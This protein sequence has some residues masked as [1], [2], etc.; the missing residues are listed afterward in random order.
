MLI[1]SG[2]L[3][4]VLSCRSTLD[5]GFS[6]VMSSSKMWLW[7]TYVGFNLCLI[8]FGDSDLQDCG[9]LFKCVCTS[10]LEPHVVHWAENVSVPPEGKQVPGHLCVGNSVSFGVPAE[11]HLFMGFQP[12][13]VSFTG[14]WSRCWALVTSRLFLQCAPLLKGT[15]CVCGFISLWKQ[16]MTIIILVGQWAKARPK[17]SLRELFCQAK[18]PFDEM[19]ELI[20]PTPAAREWTDH[21]CGGGQNPPCSR[22]F[23][24]E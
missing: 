1:V 15:C 5:G 2:L 17:I 7:C 3:V 23:L 9:F 6:Y 8:F 20:S 12:L 24:L 19:E 11:C 14:R 16:K 4:V 18:N 22:G 13:R 21:L 10:H